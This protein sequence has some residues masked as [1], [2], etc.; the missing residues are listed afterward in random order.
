[1]SE[2]TKNLF[3]AIGIRALK[4][5]AQT[6]VGAIG[7]AALLSEVNWLQC[8]SAATLAAIVSILMNIKGVPEVEDLTYGGRVTVHA[9]EEEDD[10]EEADKE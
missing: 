7:G 4:T 10:A 9:I 1:M 2:Y 8:L 6:F 5:F 3:K